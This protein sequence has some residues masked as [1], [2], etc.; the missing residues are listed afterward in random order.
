MSKIIF[1]FAVLFSVNSF[2]YFDFGLGYS[3]STKN[4]LESE[5][6]MRNIVGGQM[7]YDWHDLNLGLELNYFSESED[8]KGFASIS[9]T[10]IELTPWARY[11]FINTDRLD[12]FF[13]VG[14]GGYQEDVE[15]NVAGAGSYKDKSELSW[16]L[17]GAIGIK[18]KFGWFSGVV[19]YRISRR[20]AEELQNQS[21]RISTNLSF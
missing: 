2:A 16:L 17:S 15:I 14:S 3:L 5:V 9:Q 7:S 12:I 18:G 10:Y 4:S 20:M 19:E 6:Q 13:G 21:L 11:N 8:Q 1:L